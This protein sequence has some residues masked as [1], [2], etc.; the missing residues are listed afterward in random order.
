ME[1]AE[2]LFSQ[3]GF[4]AVSMRQI[5]SAA[6]VQVGSITYHFESKDGLLLSIYRHHCVPMN[7]RRIELMRE[8][9]R[10]ENTNQRLE[11]IVRAFVLPALSSNSDLVGGGARFARL[12]AKMSAE[13]NEAVRE[14]I[15]T[16]FDDTSHALIDAIGRCLPDLA[17]EVI[18]WR[19]HFLLGALYYTLINPERVDRLSRG[20][21]H[22][23]DPE[24][25]LDQLVAATVGALKA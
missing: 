8:A 12:R 24:E 1:A 2:A 6:G 16:T 5:A 18:V 9:E 7:E 17:R 3:Q 23:N 21:A 4:R 15:A 20:D 25:V 22:G 10:I 13:G 11:A 14:V 19:C